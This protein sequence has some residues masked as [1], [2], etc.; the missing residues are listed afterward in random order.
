MSENF[1]QCNH[2]HIYMYGLHISDDDYN[3]AVMFSVGAAPNGLHGAPPS[4]IH[5]RLSPTNNPPIFFFEP[6]MHYPFPPHAN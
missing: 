5:P 4:S 6:P 3:C 2:I 1:F